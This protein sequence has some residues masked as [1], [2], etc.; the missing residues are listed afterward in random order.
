MGI[1][2]FMFSTPLYAV[3]FNVLLFK[4]I[5]KIKIIVIH[6]LSKFGV[7]IKTFL[8]KYMKEFNNFNIFRYI[9]N[10]FLLTYFSIRMGNVNGK[11]TF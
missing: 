5:M 2:W 4:I 6:S 3:G 9:K 11:C 10:L 8:L 7:D 1:I